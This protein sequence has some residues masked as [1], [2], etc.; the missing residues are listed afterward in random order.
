M[1]KAVTIVAYSRKKVKKK[2]GNPLKSSEI[3][4]VHRLDFV[5]CEKFI[6]NRKK[7]WIFSYIYG[8]VIVVQSA[9][10]YFQGGNAFLVLPNSNKE[11]KLL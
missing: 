3:R 10:V 9:Q 1:C 7:Y 5:I 11:E 2:D 6:K 8:I 4:W